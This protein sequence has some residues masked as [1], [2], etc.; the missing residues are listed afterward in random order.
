MATGTGQWQPVTHDNCSEVQGPFYHGT[1]AALQPGDVLSAG[2]P[3]NFED[4][5]IS[6]HIYFS[7]LMEPAIWGAELAMALGGREGRGHVY[8]VRP[9]GP[10]EDDP[11]LTNKRFPGN[12]TQSYRTRAPLA[13]VAE[14]K[15]WT[16]HPPEVL[17]AM[18]DSLDALRRSGRAV[19]ED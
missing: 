15:D 18:L 1:K 10:F 9:T 17:Q 3:S 12:P 16:G 14:V 5:R 11:N 19:I 7:A 2:Q 6:N 13:I 4:G 8:L